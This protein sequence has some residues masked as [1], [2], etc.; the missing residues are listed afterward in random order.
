MYIQANL[1]PI[2]VG[3]KYPSNNIF[4][5]LLHVPWCFERCDQAMFF[6][7]ETLVMGYF[8]K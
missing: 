5:L 7:G 4:D 2:L 8:G 1:L 3:S 6:S